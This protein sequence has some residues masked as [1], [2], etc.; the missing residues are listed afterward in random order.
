[1]KKINEKY[2]DYF[3]LVSKF[4]LGFIFI[5]YGYNKLTE[6]QFG[7][8]QT[9]LL[10]PIKDL[11]LFRISWYLFD[12]QPFK[13]FIGV[14]QIICG[15]LLIINRTSLL[16]SIIFIP[17]ALNILI[18]DLTV[19]PYPM[20][21]HF[22]IRLS[23]YLFLDF[24][25]LLHY[26]DKMKI[27]WIAIYE[28]IRTKYKVSILGYFLLPIMAIILEL[29]GSIPDII[30]SFISSPTKTINGIEILLEKLFN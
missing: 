2:W 7:L 26:K 11:S 17:I 25:I 20:N 8:N 21:I 30:Y 3:I 12:H 18:I 4:L 14:S 29:I 27:V 16:G 22:G 9:E 24:L 28:N 6:N 10:T 1:M 19:M 15:I 23:F 5:S 13:Y